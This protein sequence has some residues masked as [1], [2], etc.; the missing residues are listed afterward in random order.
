MKN[1][2]DFINN[3]TFAVT[4]EAY[5][6]HER[7]WNGGKTTYSSRANI[8]SEYLEE[9]V[10]EYLN[11]CEAITE[12]PD[13]F[14]ADVRY[15]NYVID[16]KEI[17]PSGWFNLDSR[18]IAKHLQAIK[19]GL[20]THFLFFRSNR[21]RDEKNWVFTIPVGYELQF[22]FIG[23][24]TASSVIGNRYMRPYNEEQYRVNMENIEW[25]NTNLTTIQ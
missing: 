17:P 12:K 24:A 23:L 21:E 19:D 18:R 3:H 2:E 22:E 5:D 14:K 25:Q 8:D 20:L 16:F 13:K 15:E 4:Q 1:I 11:E 10:C 7:K 6:L 9:R